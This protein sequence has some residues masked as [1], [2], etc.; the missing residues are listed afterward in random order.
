MR[1][2]TSKNKIKSKK[3]ENNK[4]MLAAL[5]NQFT[6]QQNRV[7]KINQ[8]TGASIWLT[9]LPLKGEGFVLN[10]QNFLDLIRLRYGWELTRLP[11]NCECVS[12]FNIEHAIS[13]KKGGFV[14]IR[15]NS[16]KNITATLLKDTVRSLTIVAP[17]G[18]GHKVPPLSLF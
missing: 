12:K 14:S 13:C 3:R 4:N 15:H 11:E 17:G 6:D 18:G 10:K 9:T 5:R 7:N 16:I 2:T 8:E 1:L